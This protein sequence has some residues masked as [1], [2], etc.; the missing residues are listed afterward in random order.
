[1]SKKNKI[2]V[3]FFCQS[4]DRLVTHHIDTDRQNNEK[5]NLLAICNGCHRR[6][7]V[8]YRKM[9]K[10][11]VFSRNK[12]RKIIPRVETGIKDINEIRKQFQAGVSILALSSW[13]DIP[14]ATLYRAIKKLEVS[15]GKNG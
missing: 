9:L 10:S 6:L 1:M 2:E 14:Y 15:E 11:G 7:H 13:W 8:I 3:C 12:I 4:G 5:G